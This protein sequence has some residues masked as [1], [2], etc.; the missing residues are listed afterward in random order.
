MYERFYK[1][2]WT[3]KLVFDVRSKL[4]PSIAKTVTLFWYAALIEAGRI[5]VQRNEATNN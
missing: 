1:R 4:A 5:E 3:T 2:G